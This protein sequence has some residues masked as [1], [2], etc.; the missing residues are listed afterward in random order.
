MEV[1]H[2]IKIGAEKIPIPSK[3]L[4]RVMAFLRD[5]GLVSFP[6]PSSF[7]RFL[8]LAPTDKAGLLKLVNSMTTQ[9]ERLSNPKLNSFIS[10]LNEEIENATLKEVAPIRKPRTSVRANPRQLVPA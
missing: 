4:Q 8:E 6:T 10:S 2:R 3:A 5:S 7:E 1:S 9:E